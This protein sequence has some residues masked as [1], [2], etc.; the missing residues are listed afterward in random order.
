[1]LMGVCVGRCCQ[2]AEEVLSMSISLTPDQINEL[3]RQ[4]DDAIRGLTNIDEIIDA[5]R[6][7]L[8]RA[9][10]LERRASDAK[11]DRHLS[12]RLITRPTFTLGAYGGICVLQAC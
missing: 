6:A 1:M 9:R 8:A 2:V 12:L 5:T 11:L 3:A 10:D 7:D 4:I